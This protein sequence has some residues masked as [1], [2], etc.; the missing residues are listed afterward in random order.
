MHHEACMRACNSASTCVTSCVEQPVAQTMS[1]C[2]LLDIDRAAVWRLAVAFA[3]EDI[4]SSLALGGVC[5]DVCR[6]C[7]EE[8]TATPNM[9][10]LQ[11]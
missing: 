3:V 1:R 8:P 7:E 6:S 9:Q 11:R 2:L 4:G 5:A 10:A